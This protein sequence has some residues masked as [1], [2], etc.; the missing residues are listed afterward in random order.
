MLYFRLTLIISAKEP[1]P[2]AFS[3]TIY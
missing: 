3:F 1:L 2:F